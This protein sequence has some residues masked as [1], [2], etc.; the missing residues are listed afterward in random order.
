M[1]LTVSR[2][3]NMPQ[4]FITHMNYA[5]CM[6]GMAHGVAINVPLNSNA[7]I[8]LIKCRKFIKLAK[9]NRFLINSEIKACKID[10]DYAEIMAPWV[11]AKTYYRLYYLEAVL[12]N[13][14]LGYDQVFKNGGHAFTRKVMTGFCKSGYVTSKLKN[15]EV[16]VSLEDANKHK[17]KIGSNISKSYYCTDECIKSVRSKIADYIE[18]QWK[19]N[20]GIQKYSTQALRTKRDQFKASHDICMIDFFYQ[21]RLKANYKDLEYLNFDLLTPEQLREYVT[22]YTS[23]AEKYA[24]ALS[25]AIADLAKLRKVP[26]I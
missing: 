4:D 25:V 12:I 19:S 14:S 22:I 6:N 11:A 8:D 2:S 3:T 5:Y 17:I 18:E 10:A 26:L 13:L 15:L 23:A 9:I 16:V 20:E 7:S 1:S 24:K 21:M